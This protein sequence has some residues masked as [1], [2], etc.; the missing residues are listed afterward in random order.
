MN[1]LSEAQKIAV[2]ALREQTG[3]S[4]MDCRKALHK[5]EWNMQKAVDYLNDS[6]RL[7]CTTDR[8]RRW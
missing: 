3:E 8:H 6:G 5:S 4:M 2:Y 1:Q 7:I